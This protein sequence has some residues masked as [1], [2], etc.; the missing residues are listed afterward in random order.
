MSLTSLIYEICN[1][2]LS[3]TEVDERI[4]EIEERVQE[5]FENTITKCCE[6]IEEYYEI[7]WTKFFEKYFKVPD[8]LEPGHEYTIRDI[9]V[10]GF[11]I[12]RFTV[13]TEV[14]PGFGPQGMRHII[15]MDGLLEHTG[16]V[17]ELVTGW[18]PLPSAMAG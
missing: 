17:L 14:F 7:A 18:F 10:N 6:K 9:E 5:F 1:D 2:D 8:G 13:E 15:L 3:Q 16:Y 11:S 4:Q 12:L